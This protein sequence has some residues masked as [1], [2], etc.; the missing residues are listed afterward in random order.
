MLIKRII[1]TFLA[2]L[3]LVSALSMVV[4][5][6]E[7]SSDSDTIVYEYNTS[8]LTP[9]M[10]YIRGTYELKDENGTIIDTVKVDT[11]QKKLDTMDLRLEYEGY[12]LY[13]DAYSGEVAVENVVTGD[14]L[15]S[16]PYDLGSKNN[17]SEDDKADMLSQIIISFVDTSDNDD[18]DTYNS[19]VY[20]VRG[21]DNNLKDAN[22]KLPASQLDVKYIKNGIRVEY[23]VGRTDSRYLV[24]KFITKET[25]DREF[26][27]II[28]NENLSDF[29]KRQFTG[30]IKQ[31]GLTEHLAQF[32]DEE[33]KEK[34]K[35][36]Y[37]EQYPFADM[38]DE[39]GEYI[40]FYECTCAVK[41]EYAA[42]ENII[43]NYF[44]EYTFE[45]LDSEHLDLGV[46][47]KEM[48]EPLFKIS[49]EY[50]LDKNGLTVRVPA[51]GIRFDES[52]Y[53][54][55]D[56]E[57]LP[58]MGAGSNPNSGYTFFPDGSGALFDFEELAKLTVPTWFHGSIYGH[59]FTYSK[60]NT[61][62]PHNQVVRYPVFGLVENETLE[63]GSERSRGY[64]AVIEEGES[65][66]TLS[67]HHSTVYN[68]VHM[69]ISPRP[70]DE[71][72]L[73]DAISVGTS[74]AFVV[75]SPRKYTGDFRIRYTM[76]TDPDVKTGEGYYDTSYVGMAKAYREYLI[77]NGTLSKLTEN[78][79]K[80]G[81][82]PLY[83]E[84]FGAIETTEKF[85]SIPYDT[86]KALTSFDDIKKMYDELSTSNIKN[87]NFILTGYNK[88]GLSVDQMP[89][90]LNWDKSVEKDMKFDEL[91]K[92]AKDNGFGLYPDFDFVFA[93]DNKMFDG[94]SLMSHAARTIDDR[95]TS[96]R[97][98]SAS[99][100]AYI[101]YFE[102]VMSPAYFSRFY[103]K[104]TKNYSKYE[105]M[106]ISV[107]TMA[108]YLNSDFD[109]DEP[110]HREDSKE[111]VIESFKYFDEH[112]SKVVTSGGNA[113]SWKYVDYITDIATDSSRHACSSA[114]VPFLGIVLHG[115]VQTAATPINMEGNTDYALLR[116]IENGSALKFIL[117]Y[118]NTAL[119]KENIDTSVYYSVRYDIW[120]EDVIANYSDI[121]KA[122]GDVQTST[123]DVHEFIDGLRIPN[124]D[125]IEGDAFG[126]LFD[127]IYKD[128]QDSAAEKE[129]LRALLQAVRKNLLAWKN[130]MAPEFQTAQKIYD[131]KAQKLTD[132]T[133]ANTALNAAKT[134]LAAAEKAVADLEK[135]IEAA[136]AAVKTAEEAL[137][138]AT[139]DNKTALE[140][141]LKDA[142][143]ALETAVTNA[144]KDLLDARKALDTA[145]TQYEEKLADMF[146]KYY[147]YKE[148]TTLAK[149][150][151][152]EYIAKYELSS[153][154][155]AKL[156]AAENDA[157]TP[158]IIA[159]LKTIL[160]DAKAPYEA[161][162]L[163][164]KNMAEEKEADIV[165]AIEKE[166]AEEIGVDVDDKVEKDENVESGFN[167]YAV[168]A[169]SIV[170]ERYS[171]GKEFILNFNNYAVKVKL[172]DVYYTVGAYGY[173]IVD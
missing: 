158:D 53:R 102:L 14:V 69:V 45:D 164:A 16:N 39:N 64:L 122:L 118:R 15:F 139:E 94:L 1:S 32:K 172:N 40:V 26:G 111:F 157:Y 103:E 59:D 35:E 60:I 48:T 108:S 80:A 84:T 92:Y 8:K 107:S 68:T 52:I 33:M 34:N 168:P 99:R 90:H 5:A 11:K 24:P 83:I 70:Y 116:A 115:Y 21:G 123:I 88:G 121:N 117:S 133:A 81:E 169:N 148:T 128:I 12:R 147:D 150:T 63:D 132:L 142:K 73:A 149:E 98:Y 55:D 23:Q 165:V 17:I 38:T 79:V 86:M 97:E 89:Y 4:S 153:E 152:A 19:Y 136:K 170:Y 31:R 78:N 160:D 57:I 37:L 49:L 29:E 51:N 106:G 162:K 67:A 131:T 30:F 43:K 47:P 2:L 27:D 127:F 56:I 140:T 138:K 143:T 112:Y 110:Y 87:V 91:L 154:N 161:L 105:P 166:Y 77:K 93:A 9:T 171:N 46:N 61:Q 126:E 113:Y 74:G 3:M 76:L 130:Y 114:T 28:N 100:Q 156:S 163:L 119:L 104:L 82:I 101:N 72:K 145:K 155:F 96:K 144:Q 159:G 42:V 109:E 173:V 85:M 65:L 13:V 124:A 146:A 134:V 125:E 167:K 58:Y 41:T 75:A 151:A 44:P 141:A 25:Y 71:Y 120:L 22:A 137:A 62:S 54:L 129:E 36:A 10:D 66:M 50:T 95:Y 6:E 20:A 18:P 7:T 135:P